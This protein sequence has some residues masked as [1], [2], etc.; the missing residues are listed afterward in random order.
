MADGIQY[1]STMFRARGGKGIPICRAKGPS[2][3][4]S[5]NHDGTNFKIPLTGTPPID[6]ANNDFD[7]ANSRF[8]APFSG[9]YYF[10]WNVCV[11]AQ[12][13]NATDDIGI[14]LRDNG[15]IIVTYEQC[16]S[17]HID[18]R[19][20]FAN[21]HGSCIYY[22]GGGDQMEIW[23]NPFS[24][25]ATSSSGWTIGSGERTNLQVFLLSEF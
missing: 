4:T 14:N 10:S 7:E 3:N 20:S 23:C 8:V 5:F 15:N 21:H 25:Y 6:I 22:C 9:Y 24:S 1:W 17:N 13:A 12:A 2:S 18:N 19:T 16:I 11:Q